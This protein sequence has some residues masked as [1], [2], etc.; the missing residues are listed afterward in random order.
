MATLYFTINKPAKTQHSGWVPAGNYYILGMDG[1]TTRDE[2]FMVALP[3]SMKSSVTNMWLQY[4][5]GG[6]KSVVCM[7][8]GHVV[9]E[10]LLSDFA[11]V[12]LSATK[13]GDKSSDYGRIGPAGL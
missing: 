13:W 10:D 9:N 1:F 7:N 4:K 12:K 6:N 2:V 5:S 3:V 11:Q 8:T